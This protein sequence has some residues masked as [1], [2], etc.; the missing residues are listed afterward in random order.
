MSCLLKWNRRRY[1]RT[2]YDVDLRSAKLSR[3]SI[4]SF[5]RNSYI[6]PWIALVLT[7]LP[8]SLQDR[9]R[10]GSGRPPPSSALGIGCSW[11]LYA[12]K[13]PDPA[14]RGCPRNEKFPFLTWQ[15]REG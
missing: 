7:T 5:R 15:F 14:L 3:A 9:S 1:G 13:Q 12:S 6:T 4:L 2:Y 11:P 10:R 8:A